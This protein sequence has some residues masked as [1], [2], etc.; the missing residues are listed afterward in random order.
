MCGGETSAASCGLEGKIA[1]RSFCGCCD[2]AYSSAVLRQIY[3]VEFV[4]SR[5]V[6]R[7]CAFSSLFL[8]RILSTATFIIALL[9]ISIQG[10]SERL[11]ARLYI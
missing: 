8:L 2:L 4:F 9:E 1:G 5:S 6:R 10:V 7:N 11:T 3:A